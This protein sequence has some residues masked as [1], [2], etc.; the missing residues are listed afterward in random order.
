MAKESQL[1]HTCWLTVC[2]CISKCA[3]RA[4]RIPKPAAK[5]SLVAWSPILPPVGTLW[6]PEV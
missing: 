6:Q 4:V 1:K 3:Q 5:A 2:M